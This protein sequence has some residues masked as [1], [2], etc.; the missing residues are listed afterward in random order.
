MRS[1][2]NGRPWLPNRFLTKALLSGE[3]PTNKQNPQP[4]LR[5]HVFGGRSRAFYDQFYSCVQ[6]LDFATAGLAI[7]EVPEAVFADRIEAWNTEK[8][9]L[10]WASILGDL[11]GC[12]MPSFQ[13]YAAVEIECAIMNHRLE[14]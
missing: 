1:G 8:L 11:N 10:F 5:F 3:I 6:S 7:M 14:H 9:D 13:K 12:Q 2:S 4:P